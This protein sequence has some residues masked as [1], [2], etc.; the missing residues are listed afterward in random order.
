MNRLLLTGCQANCC[1]SSF[2]FYGLYVSFMDCFLV[3]SNTME[4]PV[5]VLFF[6]IG[7]FVT[8]N[9]SRFWTIWRLRRLFVFRTLLLCKS[10]SMKLC[11]C[12]HRALRRLKGPQG[13]RLNVVIRL[14]VLIAMRLMRCME[15]VVALV[16]GDGVTLRLSLRLHISL[17]VNKLLF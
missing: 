3:Q 2:Y 16:P 9:R 7:F 11:V 10:Y 8:K 14:P 15:L 6:T 17:N 4:F 13:R 12:I 1:V 5:R